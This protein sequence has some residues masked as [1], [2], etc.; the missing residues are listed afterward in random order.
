MR[1]Q[2]AIVAAAAQAYMEEIIARFPGVEPEVVCEPVAGADVWIRVKI[3]KEKW[4]AW[5]AVLEA[6]VDLNDRYCQERGVDIVSTVVD[7][8]AVFLPS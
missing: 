1:K 7:K 3:P 4:D 8:E 2:K 5:A 6:T